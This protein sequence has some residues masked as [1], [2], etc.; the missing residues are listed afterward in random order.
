MYD[1]DA[2]AMIN[3]ESDGATPDRTMIV[4]PRRRPRGFDTTTILVSSVVS[5][6]FLAFAAIAALL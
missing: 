3:F 5:G 4:R 2:I 6:A 1:L